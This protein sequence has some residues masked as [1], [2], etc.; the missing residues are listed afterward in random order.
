MKI[1]CTTQT[2]FFVASLLTTS[3]AQGNLLHFCAFFFSVL[4][5]FFC[6]VTTKFNSVRILFVLVLLSFNTSVGPC[7]EKYYVSMLYKYFNTNR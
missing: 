3:R 1:A 6:T 7:N 2:I 4:L 5:T